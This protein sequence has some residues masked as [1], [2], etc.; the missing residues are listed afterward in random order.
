[1]G[2]KILND[3]A[4][5]MGSTS[6]RAWLIN[7]DGYWLKGS[8]S[9]QE[10]G[11]MFAN[12]KATLQHAYPTAWSIIMGD[13]ENQFENASGLWTFNTVYPLHEGQ[14]TNGSS[15]NAFNPSLSE[16]EKNDFFW[17]AVLHFPQDGYYASKWQTGSSVGAAVSALLAGLFFGCWRLAKAWADEQQSKAELHQLNL[18]LEQKVAERTQELQ[19][20]IEVRKKIDPILR[21][22]GERFHSITNSTSVAII[23]TVDRAG[24]IMTWN[25]AAESAFGYGETEAIGLP[26]TNIMPERYR[27]AHQNGLKAATERGALD[28]IDNTIE[29]YGLRKSGQEF[30]LEFSL[31][32][33]V[34]DDMR[35]FSA[36]MLDITERKAT[37]EKLKHLATHDALTGLPS[38]VLCLDHIESAIATADRHN[39]KMAVLFIDLDDFKDVNDTL[40]HDAGDA[41]LVCVA[42]RLL[43]C[44]RAMDT[45]ARIGG[46][47]FIAILSGLKEEKGVNIVV[48]KIM[49]SMS[50]PFHLNDNRVAR[51]GASIGMALYPDHG[52]TPD[53]LLKLADQA[54]YDVKHKRGKK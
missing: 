35:Y 49:R 15:N 43:S 50:L 17:K 54:M 52:D 14:K 7:R 13:R 46:D 29:L 26:V 38:R 20:E 27:H 45:V 10:W 32:T 30:P 21:A 47:E 6:Q 18:D 37:E 53:Q 48:D 41:L 28:S 36:V 2:K 16:L 5:A 3:Y 39:E 24:N 25:R 51:I 8:S 44:V 23:I 22:R 11:F 4:L 31:G 19:V 9:D 12:P 34:Q 40:G 42:E 33:W 1:M